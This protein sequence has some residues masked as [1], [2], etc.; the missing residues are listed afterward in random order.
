MGIILSSFAQPNIKIY[1]AQV[2]LSKSQ[3]AYILS[4]KSL[5]GLSSSKKSPTSRSPINYIYKHT[6]FLI[7]TN[8]RGKLISNV[9]NSFDSNTAYRIPRIFSTNS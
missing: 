5:L 2:G 6:Y 9:R 1:K 4:Y 8:T 3:K 7:N